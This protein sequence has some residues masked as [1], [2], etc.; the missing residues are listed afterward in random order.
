MHGVTKTISAMP[1]REAPME[2]IFPRRAPTPLPAVDPVAAH[3]LMREQRALLVDVREA[4]EWTE[5]RIPGAVHIPLGRLRE[6]A[7]EIPRDRPVILQCQSGNRSAGATRALLDL[8]FTNVRNLEGGI[9]D[10]AADGLPLERG[11][12]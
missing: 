11:G 4:D 5:L 12:A 3:E 7:A 1:V 8:G 6:R 9:S 10:W 2:R